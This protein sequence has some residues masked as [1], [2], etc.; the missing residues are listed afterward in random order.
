MGET[1]VV[2]LAWSAGSA[3]IAM[4]IT[5]KLTTVSRAACKGVVCGRGIY[6]TR[7][8][9]ETSVLSKG[10]LAIMTAQWQERR[11]RRGARKTMMA[12]PFGRVV[13]AKVICGEKAEA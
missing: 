10:V 13:V 8:N 11:L 6:R 9:V 4:Q 3:A 2:A 1:L 5:I 7:T 12:A